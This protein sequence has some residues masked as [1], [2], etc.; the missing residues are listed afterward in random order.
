MPHRTGASHAI[1]ALVATVSASYLKD[2]L[3]H[4]V[5]TQEL[6]AYANVVARRTLGRVGMATQP[7]FLVNTGSIGLLLVL[8]FLWGWAYHRRT[9]G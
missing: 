6:V 9:I 7:D 1:A 4:L 8:T 5:S 3:R 2:L